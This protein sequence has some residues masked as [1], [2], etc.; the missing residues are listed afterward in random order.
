[1]LKIVLRIEDFAWCLKIKAPF[2]NFL[3][4]IE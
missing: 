1:M 4:L 3:L 2:D